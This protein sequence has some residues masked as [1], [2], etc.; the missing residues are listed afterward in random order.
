LGVKR[1]GGGG[2]LVVATSRGQR[3]EHG[4]SAA[5]ALES[6]FAQLH[7]EHRWVVGWSP[8]LGLPWCE[9]GEA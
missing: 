9:V 3:R 7:P 6:A 5:L 8:A 1:I 4:V 2:R